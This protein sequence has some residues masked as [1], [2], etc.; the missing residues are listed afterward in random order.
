MCSKQMLPQNWFVNTSLEHCYRIENND[1]EHDFW[2]RV[3]LKN[4]F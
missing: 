3:S 4:Y 2:D 1:Y